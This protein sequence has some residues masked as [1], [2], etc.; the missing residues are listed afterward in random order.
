MKY[1]TCV[2]IAEKNPKKIKQI[3]R[4]ALSK[5]EFAEISDQSVLKQTY[6]KFTAPGTGK[7]GSP[8][9]EQW[10]IQILKKGTST[11]LWEYSLPWEGGEKA[12]WSVT[13]TVTIE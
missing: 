1:K 8:G 3:L 9:S 12:E 13:A 4:N 5:S 7:V 10:G 11:L 2:S 6:H